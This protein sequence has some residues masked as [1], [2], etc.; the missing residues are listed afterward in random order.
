MLLSSFIQVFKAYIKELRSGAVGVNSIWPILSALQADLAKNSPSTSTIFTVTEPSPPPADAVLFPIPNLRRTRTPDTSINIMQS[1]Q[2][3]PVL[4]SLIN[5]A[6]R[7]NIIRK[8]VEQGAKDNRDVAK[9]AK[10]ALRLENERWEEEK[11]T[12]L[13]SNTRTVEVIISIH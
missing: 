1:S 12:I 3:I 6:L 4:I 5:G 11:K 2:M 8:E 10:E 7:T 13:G 9:D